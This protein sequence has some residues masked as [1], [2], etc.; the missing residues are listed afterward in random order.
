MKATLITS[1][2]GSINDLYSAVTGAP[3]G[4][5][6]NETFEKTL[7]LEKQR[8]KDRLTLKKEKRVTYSPTSF[9]LD[10]HEEMVYNKLAE[11][12]KIHEETDYS[13][14]D[15]GEAYVT[16]E[17]RFKEAFP[18]EFIIAYNFGLVSYGLPEYGEIVSEFNR[19]NR[20]FSGEKDTYFEEKN[21]YRGY[22]GMTYE[23]IETLFTRNTGVLPNPPITSPINNI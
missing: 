15:R 5:L 2:S 4:T 13:V 11:L 18:D 17:K 23:K 10:Y 9:K 1:A 8:F 21:K 7:E 19:Q 20:E 14:M 3:I 22:D 6:P 12:K 16:I